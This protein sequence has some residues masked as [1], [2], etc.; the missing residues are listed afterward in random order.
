MPDSP[1]SNAEFIKRAVDAGEL[2]G[3]DPG[4]AKIICD[5]CDQLSLFHDDSHDRGDCNLEEI[6]VQTFELL[7]SNLAGLYLH[8]PEKS[9][10][11]SDGLDLLLAFGIAGLFLAHATMNGEFGSLKNPGRTNNLISLGLKLA[12]ERSLKRKP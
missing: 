2:Q 7:Y 6:G 12:I 5:L 3:Y 8:S 1:L 11:N 10:Q 4:A 9:K